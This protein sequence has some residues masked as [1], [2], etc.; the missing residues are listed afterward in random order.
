[1]VKMIDLDVFS[2]TDQP[3]TCPECGCRTEFVEIPKGRQIHACPSCE[4]VYIL[5]WN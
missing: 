2:M 5:E 3:E 1:M 4:E